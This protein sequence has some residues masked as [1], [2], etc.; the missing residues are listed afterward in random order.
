MKEL[1]LDKLV[2]EGTVVVSL[3]HGGGGPTV[4]QSGR[5]QRQR[6]QTI[7]ERHLRRG[8]RD[9]AADDNKILESLNI[10]ST[11]IDNFC[12]RRRCTS[13]R[14]YLM[15]LR[16]D[17][18]T[19]RLVGC[20][21]ERFFDGVGVVVKWFGSDDVILL[22][23]MRRLLLLLSRR[24]DQ[25]LHGRVGIDGCRLTDFLYELRR[26]LLYSGKRTDLL[27]LLLLLVLLQLM[28]NNGLFERRLRRRQS[29][30]LS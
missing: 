24:L 17:W 8:P 11:T 13:A 6:R 12:S 7:I 20:V 29:L 1:L 28:L 27:L 19:C 4:D 10:D 22:L 5:R 30:V 14:T 26:V 23:L 15:L 16:L 3:L 18:L 25:L 9:A 21:G 2:V